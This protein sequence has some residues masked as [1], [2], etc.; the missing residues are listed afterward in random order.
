MLAIQ[1]LELGRPYQTRWFVHRERTTEP[2]PPGKRN[3]SI[4]AVNTAAF[5]PASEQV[6]FSQAV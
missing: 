1:R 2:I 3:R 4:D 6:H 5:K